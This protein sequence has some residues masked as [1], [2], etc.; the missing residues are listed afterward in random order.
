M[1]KTAVTLAEIMAESGYYAQAFPDF[2]Q[3]NHCLSGIAFNRI[4][5]QP[6]RIRSQVEKAD[7]IAILK[8][9][10]G[11]T[12]WQ[13]MAHPETTYIFNCASMD[14]VQPLMETEERNIQLVDIDSLNDQRKNADPSVPMLAVVIKN[15]NMITT[16]R[17]I[18]SLE[19]KLRNEYNTDQV[20]G[21]IKSVNQALAELNHN[22]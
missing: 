8:P 18:E 19:K 21:Y 7:I 5:D 20:A 12:Q 13:E 14:E 2:T 22:E 10:P 15:L 11:R 1:F 4:S 17:L 16:E 3:L 6:I 9:D